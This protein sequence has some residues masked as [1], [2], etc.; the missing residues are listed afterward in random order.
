MTAVNDIADFLES[1][2]PSAL[3][4]SWDNVGL[5]IGDRV[6]PVER[7][8]TCLTIT[9]ESAAEAVAELANLIVTH[10][11]LPFRPQ[12]RLTTDTPDGRLLLQ[13]IEAGIAV[14]SPHT[15]FDSA[16]AGIN[17]RLATGLGLLDIDVLVPAAQPPLG[18]GRYGK[19]PA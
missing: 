16:A 17:Q 2:A 4:E 18:A 13:L 7:V 8:M 12:N 11:P 1:F 6:R 3:A 10:H 14:Y 5:L 15:A 9:P 19:L